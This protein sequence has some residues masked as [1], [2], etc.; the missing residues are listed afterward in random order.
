MSAGAAATASR[1]NTTV[2]QLQTPPESRTATSRGIEQLQDCLAKRIGEH[3]LEMWFARTKFDASDRTLH[4]IT[5]SQFV[6]RW[7]EKHFLKDLRAAAEQALGQ[8]MDIAIRVEPASKRAV[9]VAPAAD[10]PPVRP[11]S[12]G[13]RRG[14]PRERRGDSRGG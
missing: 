12:P 1:D 2:S 9:E 5:D 8:R 14:R 6:A 10:P 7:I 11:R 3:R 4:V 13:G